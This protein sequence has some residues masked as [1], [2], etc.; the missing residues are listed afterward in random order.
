M[1]DKLFKP[2]LKVREDFNSG[3]VIGKYISQ[4]VKVIIRFIGSQ[5]QSQ[6]YTIEFS[7]IYRIFL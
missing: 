2:S 4:K 6:K 7:S 3:L 1:Y 5:F